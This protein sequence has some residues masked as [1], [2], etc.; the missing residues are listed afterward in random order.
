MMNSK[1][2][3]WKEI[4]SFIS[5]YFADSYGVMVTGSFVTNYFNE[6]S[7]IDIIIL[8]NLFRKVYIDTYDYHGLKM[9]A[10][11]FPVFDLDSVLKRDIE[12]GGIYLSQIHKGKIIKDRNDILKRFK[13]MA[14]SIY[15]HGPAPISRY[16][17]DHAKA[18]ITT[19]LED[20]E[21]NNNYNENLFTLLDIYPQIIHLYFQANLLWPYTGKSASRSIEENDASFHKDLISSIESM[22]I[23]KDK[24]HVIKFTKDFLSS[25]GGEIHFLSTKECADNC[26]KDY[27][28]VFISTN[29]NI[30]RMT[31]EYKT[32]VNKAK[33]FLTKHIDKI[34]IFP[35]LCPDR[36]VYKSG[37][38]LIIYGD[39]DKLN[40]E[41]LP[42]IEMFHL[43]LNN[44]LLGGIAQ[45]FLYPYSINP[46]EVFG[47]TV[48]QKK[49]ISLIEEYQLDS[50]DNA[51]AGYKILSSMKCMDFFSNSD[52]WNAFWDF[53]YNITERSDNSTYIT[54]ALLEY[55]SKNK[56]EACAAQIQAFR[57]VI[58][59]NNLNTN[60]I[61]RIFL[62]LEKMFDASDFHINKFSKEGLTNNQFLNC[63]INFCIFLVHLAE[64]IL[65][66]LFINNNNKLLI[67]YTILNDNNHNGTN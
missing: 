23:T 62:E 32:L 44:S 28:V 12:S 19:K 61:M 39:K 50:I 22:I 1:D 67:A 2:K 46:L 57:E 49:I 55:Y 13:L 10:I 24:S 64:L 3:I 25:L 30:T 42:F 56:K 4:Y 17:F 54:K 35:Y 47:D 63:N 15:V 18:R 45:N 65:N 31:D 9:Q 53:F 37:L 29:A 40:D 8:S 41:V 60:N 48:I 58:N 11:I 43:D 27:L 6:S 16:N 21:G 7:D 59:N 14:E 38:Y 26:S 51:V 52:T 20:L 66:S 36:R 5:E 33:G 34:T